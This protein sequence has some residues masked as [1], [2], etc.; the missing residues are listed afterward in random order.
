MIC[1]NWRCFHC[2]GQNFHHCCHHWHYYWWRNWR[3]RMDKRM[4]L[5]LLSLMKYETRRY[6]P[7]LTCT[8]IAPLP[9][10]ACLNYPNSPEHQDPGKWGGSCRA[11]A[12]PTPG[13][14]ISAKVSRRL[15]QKEVSWRLSFLF[16]DIKCELE[17]TL[18]HNSQRQWWMKNFFL[19]GNIF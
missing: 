19:N 3:H 9:E 6:Y 4:L 1:Q 2:L 10:G 5:S 8:V 12:V 18:S 15:F 7:E 16:W 13:H 17:E 11:V 14:W